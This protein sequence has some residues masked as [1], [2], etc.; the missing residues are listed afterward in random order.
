MPR[1]PS[2]SGF[3]KSTIAAIAFCCLFLAFYAFTPIRELQPL[4]SAAT[5]FTVNSTAD[6][7]DNNLS[8][9]VCNDGTGVCTFRAAVQ[10]ANSLTGTDTITFS[11]PPSS[12]ITLN[13]VLPDIAGNLNITG[14]GSSQLT[15]ARSSAVGTPDFRILTAN[16]LTTNFSGFT[17]TNGSTAPGVD[18][19][20]TGGSSASGAGIFGSG[21]MTLT[22]VVITGN[23]TGKAGNATNGGGTSGGFGGGGAG[24]LFS[25]SLTATNVTVSNN[26]TG[27]G[28]NGGT[29][30][31]GGHGAGMAVVG[32]I[33]MTHCFVTGNKTGNGGVGSN[34][35]ATGG[36]GGFGAGIYSLG[37]SFFNLRDVVISNNTTGNGA[38]ESGEGGF[39]GG[40][41]L[42]GNATIINSTI[43]NNST[44][45][46]SAGFVGQGGAGG[47]LFS[48]AITTIIGSTVSGNSTGTSPNGDGGN[49]GGIYSGATLTVL[50]TTL[51]GN[52]TAS[53]GSAIF[54]F[55]TVK[56]TN[57]TVTDNRSDTDTSFSS[58]G[59]IFA[60]SSTSFSLDNSILAKNYRG[61]SP[62]IVAD[63]VGPSVT[64]NGSFNIIGTGGS[65]GLTN[66]VNNNQ[67]G[68][69][70]QIGPL[71]NNGGLT[72]THEL[73]PAS[74][75]IDAGSNAFITNPPS[76]GPPFNDQRGPGFNRIVDGPDGD[77]T[78]TV[79]I[80][81][82]E[83]QTTFP[84]LPNVTWNEDATVVVPFEV[85]D[86]PSITSITATSSNTV[87]VPGAIVVSGTGTTRVLNITLA[88]NTSGSS[89]INVTVNRTGGS[90]SQ[91]F[92]L[93]VNPVNDVPSFTK[94]ADQTVNENDPAQTI[95][96][97]ATNISNGAPDESGQALTFQIIG[98]TNVALFSVAPA[99][100]ANGTLTYTPAPGVSGSATIT[101]SLKDDGGTSNGGV[102]TSATQTFVIMCLKAAR[103]S[104]PTALFQ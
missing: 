48:A 85:L 46:G 80:G 22:D 82:Y 14:P 33:T 28:G 27:D 30:R 84:D 60:F 54:F 66:G 37:D 83:K 53:S 2:T 7:P 1:T 71:A 50:N 68:V 8:D 57:V 55:G 12:T 70:P 94:G 52:Q 96:S 76:P 39:G 19:P 47:G 49:G 51:S 100:S 61:L 24:I 64:A 31:P 13:T 62:S 93:T 101:V 9:G 97:W 73:L 34:G 41:Y 17:I 74:T 72:Q 91:P 10:Q 102:D 75:A 36:S 67:V 77:S 16:N 6:T 86:T 18:A 65:G 59:A 90:A 5:T 104:F 38:G 56:L 42:Q 43:S 44:G 32:T 29:G 88:P 87:L 11:L 78:A 26:T 23:K 95:T 21:T 98:N 40:A 99:I 92:T 20:T 69:D 15:I 89:T 45:N 3:V 35:G 4:A 58:G 25:G 81:A 103:F 79:D 63:D